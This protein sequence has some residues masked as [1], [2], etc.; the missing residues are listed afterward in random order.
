MPRD[1]YVVIGAGAAAEEVVVEE[2]AAVLPWHP[3]QNES[4]TQV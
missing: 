4:C 1:V 3:R 2:H